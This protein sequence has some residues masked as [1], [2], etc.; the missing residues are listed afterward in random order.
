MQIW[1]YLRALLLIA[2]TL[3]YV[4]NGAQA[5]MRISAGETLDLMMC[6]IGTTK[7]TQL[8]I[9]GEPPEETQGT[10]CGDCASAA[11]VTPPDTIVFN[12]IIAFSQPMPSNLPQAITP[13]SPLWPG[14]PPHGPPP[15][16]KA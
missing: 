15:P 5:H 9:P 4:A 8:E 1:S 16:H 7:V 2:A 10:Y 14:A 3:G 12:T 13:R 11:A 6:S